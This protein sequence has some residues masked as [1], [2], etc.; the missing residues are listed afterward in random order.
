[1]VMAE[2]RRLPPAALLQPPSS[3]GGPGPV[4]VGFYEIEGT[5]GKGNFAVVKLGRHRITRS[6][7]SGPRGGEGGGGRLRGAGGGRAQ[8]GDPP[9]PAGR[10]APPLPSPTQEHWGGGGEKKV[11]SAWHTPPFLAAAGMPAPR[12]DR[13]IPR[14]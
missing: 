5:L 12:W 7:V 3:R 6:E 13:G 11:I 8:P 2:P 9:Q 1:M 14:N 4:R 10:G